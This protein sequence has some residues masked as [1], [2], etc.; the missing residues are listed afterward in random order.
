MQNVLRA[1]QL[2]P[3]QLAVQT[4]GQNLLGL[5]LLDEIVDRYGDPPKGVLN[6]ID[7]ALLRARA[8][9][10]AVTDITQKGNEV[11]FTLLALDREALS[12]LCAAPGLAGRLFL[13]PKT[14][15]PVLRLRLGRGENSLR[16]AVSLVD[17]LEEILGVGA[18]TDEN[19]L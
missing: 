14:R 12:A 10:L 16:A 2:I 17:A 13:Q 19:K 8:A 15:Q 18:E 6:L 4:F 5:D 9:K 7:V 11:L 1:P 3:T